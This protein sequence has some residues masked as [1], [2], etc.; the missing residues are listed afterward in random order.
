MIK[1]IINADDLGK[2]QE[3]NREIAN[4]LSHGM[5]TSSTILA[6]SLYWD[7]IHEIVEANPTASFGV[8]LNLTEGKALTNNIVF[9]SLGIVD[10]NNNFTKNIRSQDFSNIYLLDAIYDEWDRQMS[11]VIT[12]EEIPVTHVDGH[13][14][15]HTEIGLSN[16]LVRILEKYNVKIARGQYNS[17]ESIQKIFYN[18][19]INLLARSTVVALFLHY[20]NDHNRNRLTSYLCNKVEVASWSIVV[21]KNAFCLPYFDSYEHFCSQLDKGYRPP[22]NTMI[23]LMCHPGHEDYLVEYN[24][25]KS[26]VLQSYLSNVVLI[27]YKDIDVKQI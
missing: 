14:H 7:E 2:S 15:I 13:H 16:V 27:S 24:M 10:D 11:R 5:I 3:V 25:I 20:L 12:E 18:K 26:R 17:I 1:V 19:V 9:H 22:N 4:A 8:H 21:M 6:N 23:E